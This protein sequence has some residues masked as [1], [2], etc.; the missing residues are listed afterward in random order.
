MAII[1]RWRSYK[2]TFYRESS[3]E[4]LNWRSYDGGALIKVADSAIFT[5]VYFLI[6][7]YKCPV[8]SKCF[9]QKQWLKE[10]SLV[11]SEKRPVFDC[12]YSDCQR[13]YLSQRNLNA[14]IKSYHDKHRFECEES[15]CGRTFATKVGRTFL[16]DFCSYLFYFPV[17]YEEKIRER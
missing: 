10:H 15:G 1:P 6:L 5:V 11:H 8:C 3:R 16:T 13:E 12:P 17:W 4:C 14:H 2:E 9:A 7:E